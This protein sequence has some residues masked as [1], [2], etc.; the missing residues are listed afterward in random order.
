MLKAKIKCGGNPYEPKY[1][2]GKIF[3]HWYFLNIPINTYR[4]SKKHKLEFKVANL[5]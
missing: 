2:K 3:L 1:L 5:F 4:L